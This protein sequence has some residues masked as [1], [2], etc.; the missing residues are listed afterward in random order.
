MLSLAYKETHIVSRLSEDHGCQGEVQGHQPLPQ[1]EVLPT[2]PLA[3]QLETPIAE[4][5]G[6]PRAV[7][8]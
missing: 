1:A 2:V 5:W 8:Q 4:T 6:F 3:V 7:L